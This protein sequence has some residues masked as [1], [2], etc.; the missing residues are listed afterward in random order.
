MFV[1]DRK[2]KEKGKNAGLGH[3]SRAR[4]S[5]F[6]VIIFKYYREIRD[7]HGALRTL[8]LLR[9]A[10]SAQPDEATFALVMQACAWSGS[11][12]KDALELMDEAAISQSS[13]GFIL[14]SKALWDARVMLAHAAGDPPVE[15]VL[16]EMVAAGYEPNEI[17]A[18]SIIKACAEQQDAVFRGRVLSL[19]EDM[20]KGTSSPPDAP[21]VRVVASCLLGKCCLYGWQC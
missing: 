12:L 11:R 13:A 9:R 8:F 1:M 18:S 21:S 15:D 2:G 17:T 6:N 7:A 5:T 3:G 20:R 14:R 19:F 16:R 10:R 4:T